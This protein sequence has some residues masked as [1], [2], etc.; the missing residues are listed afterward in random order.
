MIQ[1]TLPNESLSQY[2]HRVLLE[3]HKDHLS[4]AKSLSGDETEYSKTIAILPF[5]EDI[6]VL[7]A[8]KYLQ[9]DDL[10]N[11]IGS[12]IVSSE[13]ILRDHIKWIRKKGNDP[14]VYAN[15][16]M[17]MKQAKE[18]RSHVRSFNDGY[19]RIAP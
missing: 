4:K 8:K 16:L 17:L 10:F 11:Y 15:A 3:Y 5:F 7:V 1:A 13:E 14:R 18:A 2:T 19:Y 6:G 12:V 9:P